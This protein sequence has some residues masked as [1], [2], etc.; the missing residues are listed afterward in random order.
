VPLGVI[1]PTTIDAVFERFPTCDITASFTWLITAEAWSSTT[2]FSLFLLLLLDI[3]S[4]VVAVTAEIDAELEKEEEKEE[5]N[6]DCDTGASIRNKPSSDKIA[7][8]NKMCK[9]FYYFLLYSILLMYL[10]Q[11][12][13]LN[14][15]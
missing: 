7:D 2:F 11:R 8:V 13:C 14:L 15:K 12:K 6:D 5:A 9:S 4:R 1:R 10:H 3:P